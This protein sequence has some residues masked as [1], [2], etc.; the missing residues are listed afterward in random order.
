MFFANSI[1]DVLAEWRPLGIYSTNTDEENK[2][3]ARYAFGI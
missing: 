1:S 3:E 2:K